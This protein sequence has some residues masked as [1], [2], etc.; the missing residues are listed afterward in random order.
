M[1]TTAPIK[2]SKTPTREPLGLPCRHCG[3]ADTWVEWRMEIVPFGTY[4]IAGATVKISAKTWPYAVCEGCGLISR[5]EP[6]AP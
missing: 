1:S 6:A 4:S 5:G 3:S 2:R